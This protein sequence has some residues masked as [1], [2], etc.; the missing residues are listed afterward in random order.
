[1]LSVAFWPFLTTNGDQTSLAQT[2]TVIS[3]LKLRWPVDGTNNTI[4][5]LQQRVGEVIWLIRTE[6][7]EKH[8]VRRQYITTLTTGTIKVLGHLLFLAWEQGLFHPLYCRL[9]IQLCLLLLVSGWEGSSASKQKVKLL[10]SSWWSR[11]W[12]TLIDRH[13]PAPILWWYRELTL[14]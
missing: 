11:Y 10:I 1:M 12:P 2:N 5:F 9:N 14:G 6:I 7:E 4:T 3:P 8:P 13:P